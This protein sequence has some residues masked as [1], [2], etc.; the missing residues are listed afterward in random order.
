M[1]KLLHQEFGKENKVYWLKKTMKGSPNW[2]LCEI[3]LNEILETT[4][5]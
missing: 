2:P 5:R 1:A 3:G 4:Y